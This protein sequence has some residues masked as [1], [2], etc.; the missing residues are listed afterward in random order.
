MKT[1]MSIIF[2]KFWNSVT[3]K[4][5]DQDVGKMENPFVKVQDVMSC[6]MKIEKILLRFVLGISMLLC[7]IN[8]SW[9]QGCGKSPI[10]EIRN[11]SSEKDFLKDTKIFL[12]PFSSFFSFPFVSNFSGIVGNCMLNSL[13]FKSLRSPFF[14]LLVLF[15]FFTV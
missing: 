11:S 10:S 12:C 4:K 14:F 3:Q 13:S 5:L 2:S 9:S 1:K 15:S 6:N 8:N 7:F